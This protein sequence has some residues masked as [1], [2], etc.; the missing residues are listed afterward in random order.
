VLLP[1]DLIAMAESADATEY[2]ATPDGAVRG[3]V[4]GIDFGRQHDPT[5]CWMLDREGDVLWTREVL[6]LEKMDTPDQ[7]AALASRIRSSERVSFDYTGPGVGLGDYMAKEYGPYDPARHLFGKIELCTFTQNFK[8]EIFPRMRRYFEA[9]TR[10]RIPISREIRE[11]LHAMQ[12]VVNNGQY[13]Y[14]AP[15]T[16]EGHSDRCTALALA[17]HAAGDGSRPQGM[18]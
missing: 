11:D 13:N 16:R 3:R 10:I 5:V 1:Y 2:N 14:W 8:R 9:P 6:V 4:L 17:C 7:R 12:Q 15:R 18:L